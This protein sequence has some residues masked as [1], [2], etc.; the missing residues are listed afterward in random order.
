MSQVLYGAKANGDVSVELS[1]DSLCDG[2]FVLYRTDG[3][4]VEIQPD[5]VNPR[6]LGKATFTIPAMPHLTQYLAIGTPKCAGGNSC[7][8]SMHL[9][10]GG[11]DLKAPTTNTPPGNPA[12]FKNVANG[13]PQNAPFGIYL[14]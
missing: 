2:D 7:T 8:L 3:G 12:Q 10:Q 11:S 6:V 5:A 4:A 13:A 14:W 1:F 9:T